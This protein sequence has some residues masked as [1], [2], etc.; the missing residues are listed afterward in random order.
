[1][2]QMEET[3]RWFGPKDPVP[4]AH[5]KQ[6]GC[7]GVVTALHHITPGEM[8]PV[9]DI[10]QHRKMIEDAGMSW[11]V[12]ESLPVSED[13][14]KQSGDYLQHIENYKQS[15]QNLAACGLKVITYN[16]MPVLDWLRTDVTYLMPDGSRALYFEQSAFIAFDLFMLKRPGA[17]KDYDN[18]KIEKARLRFSQMTADEK[19]KLYNNTLLGLPGTDK[20]FTATAVLDALK[21]YEEIDTIKLKEHLFYFLQ[22]VIP[23]AFKHGLKMAIHPDDPPYPVLGLPRIVSTEEDIIALI[24][25]VPSPANGLCFC[26]GSLG[27]RKD[28]DLTGI[29]KRLGDHIHFIHLRNTKSDGEGNFYEADHLNGDVNMYAIVKEIVE[30]MKRRQTSIPMRPD[31]GH[32]MLDDL[33]KTTYP[34]YS[35][36]GRLKG[37]AELRGLQLGIIMRILIL[38]LLPCFALAQIPQLKKQQLIVKGEPYLILGGELGNSTASSLVSMQPVWNTVKQMHL[39]TVLTPV[40]WELMEP[41]EGTFDFTLIDSIV[42]QA[43]NNDIHLILLWFGAWKNSMSCYAPAWVK[44]DQQRFPRA[45]NQR[46]AG[47]EILSAFNQN[48]LHADANAFRALMKHIKVIDADYSTVI[49]VQVENEIGMLTEAREY[50]AAAN[51]AFHKEVPSTLLDYLKKQDI[52]PELKKHWAEN[53]SLSKGTWEQVFGKSLATDELFQ[54]WYYATYTNTVALAGKAEYALPMFVNTALNYKNVQPGQYPSAGPLPHLMDIWQAAAP[55]IDILS[56]DFYNPYFKR[57]NDL[58]T[59]RNN[60][61]FIPEIR[62]E[63]ANAAKV[64]YAVGHYNAIGFSPFSIESSYDASLGKS[65]DILRQLTPVILANKSRMDG[66][67][68]DTLTTK[69]EITMGQYILS[70][71]HDGTL[72]WSNTPKARWPEAGGIIIQTAED[73]FIIAGTTIVVTFATTDKVGIL[74]ADEGEYINGQW[75]SGK[76]LNGDQTHQG[77][78]IRIPSGEWGIQRVKLY[79]YR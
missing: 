14:K 34:G 37:L 32:Q 56:P 10:L 66:V 33:N 42:Y 48:N 72:G 11:T 6:A 9:D 3:M 31:H 26:T 43:R 49:M 61:L 78:H 17:E 24:N 53:G 73:E 71:A 23:V 7:T 65:Y 16:F 8:W 13:I 60:P 35:A 39:N 46:G 21:T 63:P 15:L 55:A 57:Y 41:V 51:E 27:V 44:I 47:L 70:V 40:Y 64:F 79:R 5:L 68:L 29:I 75:T 19:E 62:S 45:Q 18:N 12:V 36:I 74:Q 38:L 28:N 54:S 4:L 25:A 69:Q 22:A 20:Q 59:R 76:R 50:T 30:L 52:V 67:L 58:Y 1:M 77:R 2:I